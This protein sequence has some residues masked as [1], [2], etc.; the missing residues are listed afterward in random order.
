MNTF[1]LAYFDQV[2]V[3][4]PAGS[5]LFLN[6]RMFHGSMPNLGQHDRRLL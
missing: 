4:M 3:T 2:V 5:G 6:A 1:R